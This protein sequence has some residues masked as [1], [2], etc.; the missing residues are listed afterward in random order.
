MLRTFLVFPILVCLASLPSALAADPAPAA[1]VTSNIVVARVQGALITENQVLQMIEQLT[2]ELE[3]SAQQTREKTAL[4]Y[5]DALESLIGIA[6]L[7]AEGKEKAIVIDKSKV[8]ETYKSV[9]SSFSSAEEFNKTLKEQKMTESDLRQQLEENLAYQETVDQATKDVPKTSE[10]DIKKF[11][12]GNQEYFKVPEQVRAAHILLS[13]DA[14]STVAQKA[15]TKKKLESLRA[16]IES[17]RITFEEA[18]AKYS[19]DEG[20][21]KKGGDLGF[22]SKGQMVKA[23]EE[24]AFAT[25]PGTYAPIVE[26]LYGYHLIKVLETK[27]AGIAPLD[28]AKAS[29]RSFL[30]RKAKQEAL[31]KHV[32]DLKGK[33]KVEVLMTEAQWKARHA[34]K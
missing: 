21:A 33:A 2:S 8:D 6:L 18:A 17:S 4:Y 15:E 25:K 29:I 16:D 1:K 23:F 28:E 26:T 20:T 30:E 34:A 5:K 31:I 13:I 3:L 10:D 7:K 9:A 24:T 22:F 11:Y 14:K 32:E 12:D 19:N 27:P